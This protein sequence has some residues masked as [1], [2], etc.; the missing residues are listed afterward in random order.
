MQVTL[1]WMAL[2]ALSFPALPP[3]EHA[4]VPARE[5]RA[6]A[7][8]TVWT[9]R[10]DPYRRGEGA[11]VY[12]STDGPAYVTVFRVDTDGRL[13]VLFPR[14]PWGD[15]FI[16][17]DREL[18]VSGARGGRSFIVDDYP[19]VG[20]IF[21]LASSAPF[22]YEDI[23]RG[24][25]WDYR[26]M[27]GGRL[28]GDP[29]VG[30]TALADR[31]SP[32]ADYDYD[33]VPYYVDGHYDYPRFV[34]YDC[35]AT[36][37]YEEWNPYERACSRFRVVVYDDPRYYPYR[38]NRGRNVV[39]ER[40][41]HLGPR[42]E[43]RDAD[44]QA[45]WVTRLQR[46]RGQGETRTSDDVGGQGSVP[47]PGVQSLGGKNQR[48]RQ[49]ELSPI[50]P[51]IEERR[52]RRDPEGRRREP[53]VAEDSTP[54]GLRAVPERRFAPRKRSTGAPKNTGEPELRRR[55]P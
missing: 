7:R 48:G 52:R 44:P 38:Y 54:D 25:Y 26:L 16:R 41:P 11:R 29:Y 5:V 18:E 3:T 17:D 27:D 36:A 4:P 51:H 46:R 28:R 14:E 40:P 6:D 23:S 20:Y 19:G 24:D 50:R 43:F 30:L 12:L 42:Y 31:I 33:I 1:G 2:A 32:D 8:V 34:C 37:S 9:D 10:E 45:E 55:R 15:S 49:P 22:A 35:H 47:A 13:R 21:A 53:T 39:A